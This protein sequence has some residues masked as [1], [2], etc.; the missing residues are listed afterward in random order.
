MAV[1]F[2]KM[3]LITLKVTKIFGLDTNSSRSNEYPQVNAPSSIKYAS[4]R[5]HSVYCMERLPEMDFA[6]SGVSCAGEESVQ[7]KDQKK[8][9]TCESKPSLSLER[10]QSFSKYRRSSLHHQK[11]RGSNKIYLPIILIFS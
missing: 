3:C 2:L 1:N 11:P 4:G 8:D 9:S 6:D 5:R 10:S 7:S